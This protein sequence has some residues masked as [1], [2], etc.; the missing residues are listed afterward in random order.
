MA[1]ESDNLRRARPLLGTFVEIGVA[2]AARAT[3]ETAVEAAFGAIDKVHRLMSFHERASDVSRLNRDAATRAVAVDDWTF[4][5]LATAGD[6]HRRSN[7]VFDIS[8]ALALQRLGWLPGHDDN[9]RRA[10]DETPAIDGIDLLAGNRVRFRRPGMK[11]DPGGIAKGFAVDRA[12]DVLRRRGMPHGIVNAGGD[13]A[14][15]GSTPVSIDLRDPRNPGRV[16][17]RVEVQNEA[18]ASTGGS[19]DPVR[20]S[21]AADCAVIDP[22][23]Q[24]PVRRL[25]GATVRAPSCMI[26]DALTKLVMIDSSSA[27]SLLAQEK[28]SA[29]VVSAH[30]EVSVTRDWERALAA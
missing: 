6:L 18:L 29:L 19:F 5:V 28:A 27:A 3:M 1:V 14:A 26:A 2:G 25:A 13:L 9:R 17:C 23:S 20:S 7:G 8:V 30:G 21:Q 4:Q 22:R 12:I 15:F 24:R 16:L 10:P 11:I